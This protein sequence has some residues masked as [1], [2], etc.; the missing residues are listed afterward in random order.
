MGWEGGD[1]GFRCWILRRKSRLQYEQV[2]IRREQGVRK[3][4]ACG[5]DEVSMG[6]LMVV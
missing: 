4:G 6:G 3:L 2:V 1:G 5:I